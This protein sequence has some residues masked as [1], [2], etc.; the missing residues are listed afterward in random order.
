MPEPGRS[1]KINPHVK[2]VIEPGFGSDDLH[3]GQTE[4]EVLTVLG[5][6][7]SVTRKYK[8]QYFYNYPS[9]GMEIDFGKRGGRTKFLYFFRSG[10]RGNQGAKVVTSHGI[11]PGDRQR[12]VLEVLGDPQ[13]AGP[14][15]VLNSGTRLGEWFS[16]AS[17]L[18]L[19][20]GED[21]RIDM[22]TV[23]KP[24]KPNRGT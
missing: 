17:G 5:K 16:Y 21:R 4:Q 8:G 11:K 6:P 19:Q 14:A 3:I 22:I 20:F 24:Y 18:N 10:V 12:R 23:T 2:L 1:P 13:K 7:E 15:T 9:Q